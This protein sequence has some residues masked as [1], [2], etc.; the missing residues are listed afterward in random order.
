MKTVAKKLNYNLIES[1]I[2][3]MSVQKEK[4]NRRP[5]ILILSQIIEADFFLSFYWKKMDF[6]LSLYVYVQ[7]INKKNTCNLQFS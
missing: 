3:Y 7:K 1:L 2:L 4:K 6:F 5:W